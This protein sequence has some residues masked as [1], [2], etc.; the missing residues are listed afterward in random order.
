MKEDDEKEWVRRVVWG[1]EW[2]NAWP[3]SKREKKRDN[4]IFI[5]K[6]DEIVVHWKSVL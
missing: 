4:S 2:K 3:F 6:A 5:L 1:V